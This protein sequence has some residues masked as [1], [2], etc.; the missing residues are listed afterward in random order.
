[1]DEK[2]QLSRRLHRGSRQGASPG[3]P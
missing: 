2:T 3:L 1:V